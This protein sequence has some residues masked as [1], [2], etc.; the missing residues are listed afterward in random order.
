MQV[1][2]LSSSSN[3]LHDKV[4]LKRPIFN[5]IKEIQVNFTESKD[6]AMRGSFYDAVG[7]LN[8]IFKIICFTCLRLFFSLPEVQRMSKNVSKND[9]QHQITLGD[10]KGI[11]YSRDSLLRM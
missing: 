11:K 1:S 5:T 9:H 7:A 8:D 4:F 3:K 10:I 6:V 2:K